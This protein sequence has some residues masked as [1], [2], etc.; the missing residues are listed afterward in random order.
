MNIIRVVPDIKSARIQESQDFYAGFL[1][2]QIA[3]D[4][5]WVITF[6]SPS[7]PTAQVT[8]MRSAES[9]AFHPQM[10]IEVDDVDHVHELAVQRNLKIVYPLSDEP[11]GVR[12]FFVVD[13]NG[14]II[15]IL[16]HTKTQKQ[17]DKQPT[18][19]RRQ[20]GRKRSNRPRLRG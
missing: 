11:W 17:S 3:M 4:M 9:G 18:K 1:G 20:R 8:V 7:N 2:F 19:A 12:R 6:V 10:S 15:N 13:P 16:S 14:V 5:D